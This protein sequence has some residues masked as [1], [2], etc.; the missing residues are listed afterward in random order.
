MSEAGIAPKVVSTKKAFAPAEK[1]AVPAKNL[2]W[3]GNLDDL[4]KPSN[5]S[6]GTK[7]E[8]GVSR[9]PKSILHRLLK[10]MGWRDGQ[11]VG[12][13]IDARKLARMKAS[14]RVRAMRSAV[15]V[16]VD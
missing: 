9:C 12:Q 5:E 2:G 10:I 6:I 15:Q 14:A 1:R 11:G 7:L 8:S 4:I 3:L 13:R 16:C